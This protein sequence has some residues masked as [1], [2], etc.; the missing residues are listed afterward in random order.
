M[1]KLREIIKTKNYEDYVYG[2]SNNEWNRQHFNPVRFKICK[3]PEDFNYRKF[4]YGDLKSWEIPNCYALWD[5]NI[6][7]LLGDKSIKEY[8]RGNDIEQISFSKSHKEFRIYGND[9]NRYL[10]YIIED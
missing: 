7:K 10:M 9:G 3:E 1:N 6:S 5:V 8:S 4:G 2:E